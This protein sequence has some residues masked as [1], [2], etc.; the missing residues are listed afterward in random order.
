MTVEE[1]Y[2]ASKEMVIRIVEGQCLKSLDALLE[3]SELPS[4]PPAPRR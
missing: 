4:S 3:F 1:Y 2:E